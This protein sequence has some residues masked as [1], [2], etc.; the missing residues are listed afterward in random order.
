M[1]HP[2]PRRINKGE[3][4]RQLALELKRQPGGDE[5]EDMWFRKE[6]AVGNEAVEELVIPLG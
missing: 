4:A 5:V 2:L 3:A 1:C 6:F